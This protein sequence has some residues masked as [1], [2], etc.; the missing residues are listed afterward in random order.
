MF[1]D[2]SSRARTL[3]AGLSLSLLLGTT[4]G[5]SLG[6]PSPEDA[7]EVLADALV[8]GDVSSVPSTSDPKRNQ[9]DLQRILEAVPD[10]QE[11]EVAVESVDEKDDVTTA[12]LS[13]RRTIAGATWSHSTSAQLVDAGSLLDR[14]DSWPWP[15]SWCWGDLALG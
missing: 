8:A 11:V 6:G 12:T 3:A 13:I 14:I 1:S 9:A 4:A 2:R 15:S 10:G 5:C 7:A